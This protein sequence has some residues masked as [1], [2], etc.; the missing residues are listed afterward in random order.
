MER[1]ADRRRARGSIAGRGSPAEIRAGN[2]SGPGLAFPLFRGPTDGVSDGT[3]T[4]G[5]LDHNQVLYQL[6]YAHHHGSYA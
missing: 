6:S 4:R 2:A 5:H 1:P 3:R